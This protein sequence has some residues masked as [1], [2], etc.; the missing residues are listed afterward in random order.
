ME[1]WFILL[2]SIN[3]L[4]DLGIDGRIIFRRI[5]RN[6]GVDLSTRWTWL[7][8]GTGGWHL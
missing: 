6:W 7:K 8:I 3:H 1:N 4:E 2:S 5:F